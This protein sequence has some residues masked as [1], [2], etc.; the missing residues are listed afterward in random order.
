MLRHIV[1]A[2]IL[3][4][5]AFAASQ[6]N[7]E[8]WC[9]AGLFSTM[10]TDFNVARVNSKAPRVYFHND[11][12][13]VCPSVDNES[14]RDDAYLIPNDT[15]V[16]ADRF[17]NNF[18]CAWYKPKEG[19]GTVGWIEL[20]LVDILGFEEDPAQK[21]WQGTWQLDS[22]TLVIRESSFTYNGLIIE[23]E[24]FWFG[25]NDNVHTGSVFGRVIPQG[26]TIMLFDTDY[27]CTL[28]LWLLGDFLVA[29]DD[30]QCGGMN[31]SFDG[32]YSR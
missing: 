12:L 4:L 28:N 7:P 27:G 18:V 25:L 6:E 19:Y 15:L 32:V 17:Y 29:H 13:Q 22:S 23:G 24:A 2:F 10:A 14:C 11:S 3:S 26:N 1:T 31:V 21:K 5:M 9:R 16:I 8:N 20:G 30:K